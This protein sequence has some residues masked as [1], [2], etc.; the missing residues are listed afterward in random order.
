[1]NPVRPQTIA[2]L[3]MEEDDGLTDDPENV[4]CFGCL[5]VLDSIEK[6]GDQ[7]GPDG[8]GMPTDSMREIREEQQRQA[9]LPVK[10]LFANG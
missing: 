5:R 1:M 9:V 8:L 6:N 7:G 10:G 4:D 2:C 3:Y